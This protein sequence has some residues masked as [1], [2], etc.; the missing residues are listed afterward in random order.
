MESGVSWLKQFPQAVPLSLSGQ[1]FHI[2][3]HPSIL[4]Y[5]GWKAR[6][7]LHLTLSRQPYHLILVLPR[8]RASPRGLE[9][10]DALG[11]LQALTDDTGS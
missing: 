9:L 6:W 2:C 7:T 8:R 5:C 4:S 1:V 3:Q 11:H 10:E